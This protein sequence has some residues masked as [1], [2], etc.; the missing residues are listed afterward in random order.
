MRILVLLVSLLVFPTAFAADI[1]AFSSEELSGGLKQ[2][3]AQSAGVAVDKLGTANGFLDNPKVKIPLPGALQKV[4]V[5][6]RTLGAGKHADN[7][8]ATMNRA[9]ETA[10]AE[11]KPLLLDAVEKM[12]VEDARKILAG[13]DNAA[14]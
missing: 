10:A 7:L 11:A 8:I 3:L 13:G 6:M 5:V 14:T 1:D 12:P 9:A 4:E 2:V